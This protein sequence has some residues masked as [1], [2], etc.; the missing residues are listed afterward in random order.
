MAQN[1]AFDHD[2][3]VELI[4]KSQAKRDSTRLQ[5][6]GEQLVALDIKVVSTLGLP[7]RLV[8]AIRECKRLRSHG[9]LSRQKQFIGKLMRQVDPEPIQALLDR[10]AG[11]SDEH[12]AWLHKL[13]RT[14]EQMLADGKTVEAFVA[15]YPAVDVQHLRQLIRNALKEREQQKPPKAYRE[16]FQ[17]LKEYIPEPALPRSD[18][19]GAVD[20]ADA[21]DEE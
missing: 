5:E 14:R 6:L 4:S 1:E 10:M 16:L 19:T 7:E 17:L 9:A 18:G 11:T 21:T 20:L 13:E 12:N 15:E 3:D 2:D 8:E